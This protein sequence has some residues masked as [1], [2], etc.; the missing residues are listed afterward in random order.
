MIVLDSNVISELMLDRPN[1]VVTHWLDRQP[2]LS[3]WTTSITVF[4]IRFGLNSM[5]PGNRQTQRI[6][7]FERIL[8]EVIEDRFAPFDS[9]AAEHAAELAAQRERIGR[10]GELR[11]TMI[12][13]IVLS[14]RATL[15]T[16][17]VKHF[18]DIARS[19]VNPWEA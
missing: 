16:R 5:P 12:A 2:Y 9:L 8:T 1:R 6:A 19:V 18:D 17:N 13:G 3:I 15:A 11:D 10:P 14:S 7:A 4:E